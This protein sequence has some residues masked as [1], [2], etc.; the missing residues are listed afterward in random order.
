MKQQTKLIGL[1]N[2]QSTV[3]DKSKTIET[4]SARELHTFLEVETRFDIWFNR[5]CE[6]GFIINIDYLLVVQKRATNNPKNPTTEFT[7]YAITLSMAKELAMIQR[8]DKGV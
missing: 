1:V 8:T 3:I 2:I 5:M 7:D 4:V 6:Y